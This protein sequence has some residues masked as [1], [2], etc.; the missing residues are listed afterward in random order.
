MK[1]QKREIQIVALKKIRFWI[2]FYSICTA[3]NC[4]SIT[5][6]FVSQNIAFVL[7]IKKNTKKS[8]N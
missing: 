5:S 3:E 2:T 6:L 7:L 8:H 4:K 1:A